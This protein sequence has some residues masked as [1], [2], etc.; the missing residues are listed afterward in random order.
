ME[1]L[2]DLRD[3]LKHEIQDLYSV[4]EQIIAAMPNMIEKATNPEL[5]QSLKEHLGITEQQKARLDQMKQAFGEEGSQ[6]EEKGL[7]SRLFKTKMVCKGMQGIITEGNQILSANMDSE[8]MDAAIIACAQKIEHYEICGYGTAKAYA[9]ELGLAE[10]ERLLDQTLNEEYEADDRLTALAVGRLNQRA[11]NAGAGK[12][13]GGKTASGAT[14]SSRSEGS[15]T[16]V[17]SG[18]TRN[19]PQRIPQQEMEMEM[20]SDKGNAT[21]RSN[22]TP[23]KGTSAP[24]GS[25]GGRTAS[26][27]TGAASKTAGS[28]TTAG[29]T[30][31]S[32]SSS[33]TSG[34]SSRSTGTAAGKSS[35]SGSRTGSTGS[36]GSSSRTR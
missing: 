30:G 13:T 6:E 9:K 34:A 4:E 23:T 29:T 18:N 10:V 24:K 22:A 5:K 12:A 15:N 8:V 31:A 28:R 11:E 26:G 16:S 21:S 3:L 2:N 17:G 36:G 25:A 19:T 7:L 14:R 35:A 32:K 27:T 1:K 20:A 33:K